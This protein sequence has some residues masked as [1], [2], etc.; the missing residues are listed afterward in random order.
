MT[1]LL[2]EVFWAHSSTL[3]RVCCISRL[4]GVGMAA[5]TTARLE[6]LVS[7][8]KRRETDISVHI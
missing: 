5:A 4:T 2:F 3:A 7:E 1:L 8:P 6:M